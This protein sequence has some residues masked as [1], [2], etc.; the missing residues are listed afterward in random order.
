MSLSWLVVLQEEDLQEH[1]ELQGPH[2]ERLRPRNP[3]LTRCHGLAQ[4]GSKLIGVDAEGCD[5]FEEHCW[6]PLGRRDALL[7][8]RAVDS[9]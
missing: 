4:A 9:G 3:A 2:D 1:G 5:G 6:T 8:H 7:R